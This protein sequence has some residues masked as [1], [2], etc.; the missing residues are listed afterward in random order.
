VRSILLGLVV[1][2][3]HSNAVQIVRKRVEYSPVGRW[4][5]KLEFV[6]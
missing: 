4:L 3:R 1:F 5:L 2:V 6:F